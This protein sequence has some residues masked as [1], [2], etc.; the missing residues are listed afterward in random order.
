MWPLAVHFE[1]LCTGSRLGTRPS[2]AGQPLQR[3]D[4]RSWSCRQPVL[5]IFL[6]FP[7]QPGDKPQQWKGVGEGTQPKKWPGSG[8]KPPFPF[9]RPRP[10]PGWLSPRTTYFE[11]PSNHPI[12]HVPLRLATNSNAADE[13][14]VWSGIL[15][16]RCAQVKKQVDPCWLRLAEDSDCL[17]TPPVAWEGLTSSICF[18]TR[19]N[20]D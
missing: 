7:W 9:P 11:E 16:A 2:L 10:P 1:R 20:L 6:L 18:N 17:R 4:E 19:Y 14:E 5:T 12:K 8:H 15:R 3:A 13:E